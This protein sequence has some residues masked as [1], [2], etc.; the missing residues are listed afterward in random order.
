MDTQN[1]IDIYVNVVDVNPKEKIQGISI[2]LHEYMKLKIGSGLP[3]KRKKPTQTGTG[4]YIKTLRHYKYYGDM[5]KEDVEELTRNYFIA[6]SDG[7]GI[8]YRENGSKSREVVLSPIDYIKKTLRDNVD[9]FFNRYGKIVDDVG[10]I[11]KI[12]KEMVD[13]KSKYGCQVDYDG[14]IRSM[15]TVINKINEVYPTGKIP[16][17]RTNLD[18]RNKFMEIIKEYYPFTRVK[19]PKPQTI[20]RNA[21]SVRKKVNEQRGFEPRKKSKKKENFDSINKYIQKEAN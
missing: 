15:S 8:K 2:I 9:K 6:D 21:C 10:D 4:K 13:Y 19:N 20:Y 1:E 5:T 11:D 17:F 7:T 14:N 18:V 3:E 16:C 12:K